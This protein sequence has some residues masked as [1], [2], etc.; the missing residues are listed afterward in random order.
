MRKVRIAYFFEDIAQERFVR[1]LVHRA[2]QNLNLHLEEEVRNATHGSLIWIEL[3]Q[4]LREISSGKAF[5][6]DML[7]VIV[8]GNCEKPV[9]ARERVRQICQGSECQIPFVVCGIPDPHIERWYLEDASAW[10]KI[11]PGAKVPSLRYQCRQDYYKNALKNTIRE[12]N[13]EPLLGG[14]EYGEDLAE[15]IDL[16]RLSQK[17]RSFKTFWQD[18]THALK[19]L[20]TIK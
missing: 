7:L 19:Q 11:L 18:L 8:D 12:V 17:D 20:T 3:R 5:T 14:A 6:P 2:T 16:Y 10:Q 15:V 9:Q 13:I 4:Y 1:R